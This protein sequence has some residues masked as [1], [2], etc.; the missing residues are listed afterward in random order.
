MSPTIKVWELDQ[1]NGNVENS[2]TFGTIIAEFSGHK[3]A[4]SCV[5]SLSIL[6]KNCFNFHFLNATQIYIC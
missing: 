3:Y 4:V 5:V 1:G 6:L 2:G